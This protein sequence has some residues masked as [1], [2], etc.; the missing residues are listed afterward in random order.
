VNID[1]DANELYVEVR[2]KKLKAEVVPL[3]FYKRK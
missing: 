1:T 3:P 2:N